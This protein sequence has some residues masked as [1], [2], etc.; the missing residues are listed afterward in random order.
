MPTE[1]ATEEQLPWRA[2]STA[3]PLLIVLNVGSG[4]SDTAEV[5]SVIERVLGAAGRP[6]TVHEVKDGADLSQIAAAAVENARE[7]GAVVVAAGGDGTI[8]TVAQATL[9]SG[10][11]FG[12]LPLGTF[13]YFSRAHGIP[14]EP[15]EA[16]RILLG[17]RAFQVQV[18]L[19]ND[20]VFLVNGSI[21]LYP[22][23]L[24]EREDAKRRLGRTRWVAIGAALKTLF[25]AH[26]QL[27]L[28]I[29][30][31]QGRRHIVTPTL[32][33]GNNRLQLE[34]V[35]ISGGAL[36]DHRLTAV[37]L[38][39]VSPLGMLGL[40]LRAIIGKLGAAE[41]VESFDFET[42]TVRSRFRARHFKVATDGEVERMRAPLRFRVAPH[43]LWLIRPSERREDPG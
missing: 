6:F 4:H 26:L 29:E 21:G 28:D 18:G 30:S 40:V 5:R 16:C 1:L 7:T 33:V 2:V 24:E 11:A 22:Q 32:F 31:K 10:C 14:S 38:A 23:L 13:N 35:G 15:E 42:L 27:R 8:N 39:P 9:G 12:V 43:A 37:T 34:R 25:T 3:A 19:V 20:R 36:D 17:D 41:Q